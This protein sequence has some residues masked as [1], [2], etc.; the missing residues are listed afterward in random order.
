MN[1]A[2]PEWS[3][4]YARSAR[5]GKRRATELATKLIPSQQLI[6][7]YASH[8]IWDPTKLAS[9]LS[10][11]GRLP[12]SGRKQL[13][14][15]L[16]LVMGRYQVLEKSTGRVTPSQLRS[17]LAAVEATT[18]KLLNQI[19]V[20]PND[21]AMRRLSETMPDDRTPSERL[22]SLAKQ[23]AHWPII[24]MRL[25]MAGIDTNKDSADVNA[26]L[27]EAHDQVADTLISLLLLYGRAKTARQAATK[28]IASGHGGPRHRPNPKGRLIRDAIAVKRVPQQRE[29]AR[30]RRSNAA[31]HSRGGD[32][33]RNPCPRCRC[34]GCMASAEIKSEIVL[35]STI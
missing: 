24:T 4:N 18:K 15:C 14:R 2:R 33:V 23:N 29:Y 6:E 25:A 13:I 31:I 10:E 26:E 16:V 11:F 8:Y 22:R 3:S 7:H 30:L 35:I 32:V 17:R 1:P 12:H 34:A 20:N 19:G 27:A 9:V 28:Y 21:L 5:D